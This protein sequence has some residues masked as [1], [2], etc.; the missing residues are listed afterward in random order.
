MRRQG[1]LKRLTRL[2][3]LRRPKGRWL[4]ARIRL[5]GGSE[6]VGDA[7]PAA[8]PPWTDF[9][10]WETDPEPSDVPSPEDRSLWAAERSRLETENA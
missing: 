2:E 1:I 4:E 5:P 6:L 9:D 7:D 8:W 10:R 3:R